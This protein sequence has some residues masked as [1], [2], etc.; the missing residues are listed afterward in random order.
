[1]RNVLAATIAVAVAVLTLAALAP[2]A[3]GDGPTLFGND[4]RVV[5]SFTA[6][7]TADGF[8]LDGKAATMNEIGYIGAGAYVVA[9]ES[10]DVR[11]LIVIE[12]D[13]ADFIAGLVVPTSATGAALADGTVRLSNGTLSWSGTDSTGAHASGNADVGVMIGAAEEGKGTFKLQES[14]ATWGKHDYMAALAPEWSVVYKGSKLLASSGEV[15]DLG[16]ESADGKYTMSWEAG[17]VLF[18]GVEERDWSSDVDWAAVAVAA[19]G[20]V[21]AVAGIRYHPAIVFLGAAVT[22]FGVVW[23]LGFVDPAGFV[24]GLLN[25]GSSR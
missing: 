14:P 1:M 2:A 4:A 13:A 11:R 21:L 5:E 19:V 25:G 9:H 20:A 24:D 22:V 23:A 15:P 10:G 3:D 17:S 8:T 18:L 7:V 12:G 6:K 16:I